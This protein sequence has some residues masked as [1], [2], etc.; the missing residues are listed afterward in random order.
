MNASEL[1]RAGRLA[2][3]IDAQIQAVKADPADIAARCS[4]TRHS[5]Y[6]GASAQVRTPAGDGAQGQDIQRERPL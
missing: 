3:A 2:E 1:Y 4:G 6:D 5:P